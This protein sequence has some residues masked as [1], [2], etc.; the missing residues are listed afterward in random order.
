LNYLIVNCCG[1][2][3][4]HNAGCICYPRF[5]LKLYLTYQENRWRVTV[6]E[7]YIGIHG[8]LDTQYNVFP[9][10]LDCW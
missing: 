5:A 2:L 3:N 1:Y 8:E 10:L 7:T 4:A 9:Y 6:L